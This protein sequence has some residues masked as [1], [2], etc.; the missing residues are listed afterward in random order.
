[1][2]S[3]VFSL[4][5]FCVFSLDLFMISTDYTDSHYLL[6]MICHLSASLN[7]QVFPFCLFQISHQFIAHSHISITEVWTE[8]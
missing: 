2:I 3:H 5:V 8:I 7:E 6:V 4:S 1:M